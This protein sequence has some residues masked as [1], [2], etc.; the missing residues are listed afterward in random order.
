MGLCCVFFYC[1]TLEKQMIQIDRT[2]GFR[3]PVKSF[4][5][6][7]GTVKSTV[8]LILL[9]SSGEWIAIPSR[10]IVNDA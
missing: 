1:A 10:W 4:A 3:D 2:V 9:S 6:R 7:Y 5:I 8:P